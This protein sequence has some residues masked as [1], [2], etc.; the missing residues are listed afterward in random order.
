MSSADEVE[1]DSGPRRIDLLV[2]PACAAADLF[3]SGLLTGDPMTTTL[4]P[5]LPSWPVMAV[6][7][8]A[9]G[10]LAWRRSHPW[11]TFLAILG[12]SLAFG[13]VLTQFQPIIGVALALLKVARRSPAR[14]AN[15]ALVL[16]A[17]AA[18]NSGWTA[19]R[20]SGDD[21]VFALIS[22][23]GIFMSLFT[24][25][26]VIGRRERRSR[27][28]TQQEKERLLATAQE[29][30]GQQRQQIARDLHDILS[31]SMS[32]MI[33]QS[34][35]AKA[36]STKLDGTT[37]AKQ[38]TEA[39][40][41]IESTGA[42]SMR[43]LHRLLGLLRTADGQGESGVARL[44]LADVDTL[45]TATRHGGLVVQ[46][47]REGAVQPLDPSVDLAAYHMVQESLTNAMKHAG[48]GAVVD[49]YETWE[50][51]ELQ[52]QVRSSRGLAPEAGDAAVP[53]PAG[54]G[55][56]LWGLRERVQL[57]GGSFESGPVDGGFVTSAVLPVRSG[58]GTNVEPEG[59]S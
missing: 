15:P 39:L 51:G 4:G 36:V 41:A 23:S 21:S 1:R 12:V 13:L 24:L 9:Y 18:L 49:I 56:G 57:A 54:S 6:I 47:H 48:R 38:V 11:L 53:E 52:L 32:A 19:T 20:I 37:E 7:A 22:I 31:H 43:E 30:L 40:T 25:I 59:E 35:G 16:A 3:V 45:I 2:V 10:V 28:R 8:L 55:T 26:W 58:R 50:P 42:E 44:R 29:S 34:A 17:F 27:V 14:Q 33:L 5:T 46:L